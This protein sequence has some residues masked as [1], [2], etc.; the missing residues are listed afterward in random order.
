MLITKD[1]VFVHMPKTG[2]TFVR[3]MLNK[4][5]PDAVHFDKH[6]TCSQVP[7]KYRHLPRLSIVRN[8]FDR[9]VSQYHYG[10]WK[11]HFRQ[12]DLN[13]VMESFDPDSIRFEDFLYI[14][15]R[16]F[17]GHFIYVPDPDNPGEYHSMK[18]GYHDSPW[19]ST[20]LGW[21][22]EQYIHFFFQEPKTVF[23]TM[24]EANFET[25]RFLSSAHDV[26]FLHTETLNADLYEFLIGI[27]H[28]REDV[29]FILDKRKILPEGG[30][31]RSQKDDWRSYYNERMLKFVERKE[32]LIFALHPEYREIQ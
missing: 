16:Y 22:T 21:H 4:V 15:D 31:P 30:N 10:W 19:L 14:A 18:N 28:R 29:D 27:G 6:G 9:Y 12:Y 3:S 25:K 8:P 32:R 20:T 13:P 7:G 5:Y 23:N 2:G 26:H 17:K 11:Q 1:F 24:T